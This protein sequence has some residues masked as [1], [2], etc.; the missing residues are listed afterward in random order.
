MRLPVLRAGGGGIGRGRNEF[1]LSIEATLMDSVLIETGLRHF[2]GLAGMA[3]DE[4]TAYR[5]RYFKHYGADEHLLIW[6]ELLTRY[7]ANYLNPDRWII[8]IEDDEENRFEPLQIMRESPLYQHEIMSSPRAFHAESPEPRAEFHRQ[9]WMLCFPGIDRT[10]V[11]VL[12]EA[13]KDLKLVFQF[14]DDR[15][16][17][18]GGTWSREEGRWQK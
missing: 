2:S 9:S 4:E 16:S 8:Y 1:P 6:C 5:A 13:V 15:D 17:R 10:G 12:S 3:P 11:P 14:M 7:A 18:A